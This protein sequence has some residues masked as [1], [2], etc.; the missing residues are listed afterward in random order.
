[1]P[2]K[3][4]SYG[5][6]E[7]VV[8]YDAKRC[9]HAEECVHGLPDVFDASRRPWID[10]TGADL[11]KLV[12]VIER[13]PTG[14]LHYRF[15]DGRSEETPA[16]VN[17][18]RL[19]PDGPLYLSG[20]LRITMPDGEV[21]EETR[22]ALCRC[23]QS[24][25]KPFCDNSHKAANFADRGITV[26]NRL[27]PAE[28]G[29]SKALEISLAQNGPILVRG[30]V[31]VEDANGDVVAGGGGALCR[32]GMAATKPFCDGSHVSAGFEAE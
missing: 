5:S 14:A 4:R 9:I 12:E 13:C 6:E 18:V 28:D 7:V 22:A 17:T 26:E 30:M 27:K 15:I 21:V 2:R 19:S 10:P 23:G 29:S 20:D 31:S 32:C 11:D 16:P 1:M 24:N 25:D 3:V 8:E